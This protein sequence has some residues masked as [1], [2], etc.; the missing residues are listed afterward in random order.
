MKRSLIFF[1]LLCVFIADV[2]FDDGKIF[3]VKRV[4]FSGFLYF[5]VLL[6][7]R[8]FYEE[9]RFSARSVMPKAAY[10]YILLFATYVLFTLS[11]DLT[12][13]GF[14]IVTL[15]NH[16]YALLAVIPVLFVAGGA[17]NITEVDIVSLL[18]LVFGCFLASWIVQIPG[19]I[20]N[21]QGY[22]S[23]HS[24]VPLIALFLAR[25]RNY[26]FCA[27]LV[28]LA[29]AYSL[30]SSDRIVMLR[31][32]FFLFIYF[33]LFLFRRSMV[34]KTLVLLFAASMIFLMLSNLE[35]I[36]GFF[37]SS[38]GVADFDSNDTRSF[39]YEELFEDL[40]PLEI[41][42]GRGYLGT[43]FSEYFLYLQADDGDFYQR[44]GSEVGFLQLV[45]K[46]GAIYYLLFTIP[47]WWIGLKSV[48]QYSSDRL[49]FAFGTF[50]ITEVLLMFFS[51]TPY[52]G[53]QFCL[54]FTLSGFCLKR[55]R[56]VKKYIATVSPGV[57]QMV[58]TNK[59][60]SMQ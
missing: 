26:V 34:G 2:C 10:A 52:F 33:G 7:I 25:R 55:M 59:G 22:I 50:I 23:S 28:A 18:Y 9:Y 53:F 8:F 39:L 49:T 29:I 27:V 17:G 45:L 13:S 57:I 40:R 3:M 20:P 21:Y 31:V 6:L 12:S 37:K 41:L 46:G 36:L 56:M 48:F 38:I 16:P 5:S 11:Q 15:A 44:F 19:S 54:L 4:V 14:S 60:I 58:R 42:K 47:L 32:L 30:N 43:Y 1:A 24:L 51:N 35:D